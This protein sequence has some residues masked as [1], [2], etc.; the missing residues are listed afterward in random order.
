M[1]EKTFKK[2]LAGITTANIREAHKLV[3][4][5]DE[6]ITQEEGPELSDNAKNM[7]TTLLDSS[8]SNFAFLV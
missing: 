2:M 6:Q 8:I 7:I 4:F 3:Q 1:D 5:I